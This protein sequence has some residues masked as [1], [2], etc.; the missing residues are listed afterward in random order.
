[1]IVTISTR[2]NSTMEI[3]AGVAVLGGVDKGYII[4]VVHQGHG[5]SAG[6]ALG[7]HVHLIVH[8]EAGDGQHDDNKEGGGPQLGQGDVPELLPAVGAVQLS[9]FVQ[10]GLQPCR[11]AR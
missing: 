6:A 11:P 2:T 3:G 8:L 5:G 4:N 7:H 1:M 10:S 9:G